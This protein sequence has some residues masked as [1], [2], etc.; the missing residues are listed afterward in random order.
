MLSC[1]TLEAKRQPTYNVVVPNTTVKTA[2]W[3]LNYINTKTEESF[4]VWK[5][6]NKCEKAVL[7]L[8]NSEKIINN[9]FLKCKS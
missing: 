5:A 8:F 3:S 7:I 6:F 4:H 1:K 2:K 9:H